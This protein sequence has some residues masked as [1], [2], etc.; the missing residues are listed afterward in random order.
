MATEAE[1]LHALVMELV[2]A[3]GLLQA[4]DRSIPGESVSMSQGFAL[5]ELDVPDPLT[6]RELAERLQLEKST[7][8]RLVGDL[9]RKELI[10]RERDPGNRRYYRLR[11]TDGGR[12]LH[13]RMAGGFHEHYLRWIAM[14]SPAERDALLLGLPALVRAIRADTS[15]PEG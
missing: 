13:R 11:L 9:E 15:S 12:A 7:V 3:A 8:S 1:R 5:H 4:G 2:R 14:M 10:V 6:Q